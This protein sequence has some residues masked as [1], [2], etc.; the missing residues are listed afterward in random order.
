M[1]D[2]ENIIHAIYPVSAEAKELII[3]TAKPVNFKKGS[4]LINHKKVNNK[5]Y[6]IS[7]GLVRGFTTIEEEEVTFAFFKEGDAVASI[8]SYVNNEPGYEIMEVLEDS[9]L[10]ELDSRHLQKYYISE[11]EVS[12]WGRKLAEKQMILLEKRLIIFQFYNAADRYIKLLETSP[13]IIQ[14]VPLK[15]IAS[16]LGINQASL[17]R[18]RGDV[19]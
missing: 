3:Q 13:E 10:F 15:Y 12:N 5:F 6:F 18:I 17:S 1:I 16:F 7:K 4:V 8:N 11:I 19:R 2:L 9:L 14:R